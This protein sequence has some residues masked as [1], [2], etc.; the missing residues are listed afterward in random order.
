MIEYDG[1]KTVED[2]HV[3]LS[4]RL[5]FKRTAQSIIYKIYSPIVLWCDISNKP[6]CH[7]MTVK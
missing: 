1:N 7:D 2:L 3:F 6:T 4:K 5:I